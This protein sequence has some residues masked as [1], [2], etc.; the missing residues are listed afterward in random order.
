MTFKK[1]KSLSPQTWQSGS[2]LIT[3]IFLLVVVA[4]LSSYIVTLRS[5][6]QATLGY[7]V[8]GVRAMQAARAGIEWGIYQALPPG[9]GESECSNSNEEFNGSGAIA[10]F[11]I[12]VT[13]K[14]QGTHIESGIIITTY[15]LTSRA[16]TG[17]YGTLDYTSRELQSR[18]SESP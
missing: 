6:Q 1:N 14:L 7:G 17:I 13:C 9:G 5:V 16:E 11:R 10:D 15:Q 8:Q 18:V 4:L 12:N 3:S 2:T